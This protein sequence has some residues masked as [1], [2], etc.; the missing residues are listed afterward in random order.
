MEQEMLR[1]ICKLWEQFEKGQKFLHAGKMTSL[2]LA[3]EF[4]NKRGLRCPNDYFCWDKF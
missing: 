4:L 2:E 3:S 1:I